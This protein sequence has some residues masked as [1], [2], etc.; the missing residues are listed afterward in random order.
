MYT[1]MCLH[2]HVYRCCKVGI[3]LRHW[4][5]LNASTRLCIDGA[6]CAHS[7]PAVSTCA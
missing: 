5:Q 2:M 4:H 7:A 3:S 6:L 1:Y